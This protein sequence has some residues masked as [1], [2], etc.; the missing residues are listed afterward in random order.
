MNV[1]HVGNVSATEPRRGRIAC[2]AH[3][4][5]SRFQYTVRGR[6]VCDKH[7]A[8]LTSAARS[9]VSGLVRRQRHLTEHSSRLARQMAIT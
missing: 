7:Q 3:T 4:S 2:L 5:I 1:K 8:E 9:R 6:I